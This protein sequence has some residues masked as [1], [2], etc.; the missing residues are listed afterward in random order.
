MLE[1]KEV[2][3]E[4]V[5]SS[6]LSY[7]IIRPGGLLAAVCS[8]STH[9]ISFQVVPL[10]KSNIRMSDHV[11]RFHLGIAAGVLGVFFYL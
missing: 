7:T 4:A 8:I 9:V 10:N 11:S 6:G 2:A 1:A 5:K 3:E